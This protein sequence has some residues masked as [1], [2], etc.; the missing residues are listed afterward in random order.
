MDTNTAKSAMITKDV[1]ATVG[2]PTTWRSQDQGVARV[3]FTT[4]GADPKLTS[5]ALFLGPRRSF[6]SIPSTPSES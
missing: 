6:R 1:D 4:K 5:N 3:I 2:G